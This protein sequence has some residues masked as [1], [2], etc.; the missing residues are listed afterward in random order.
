MTL[1]TPD[2]T[3]VAPVAPVDHD[4]L[5]AIET[6]GEAIR[7]LPK[8]PAGYNVRANV[9]SDKG[10]YDRALADINYAF[11]FDATLYARYLRKMAEAQGVTRTE[12]KIERVTQREGLEALACDCYWMG[13]EK[14][15][16]DLFEQARFHTSLCFD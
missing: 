6:A 11:H 10:D 13:Q 12:G 2:P 15:K 1:T 4:R 16:P 14:V 8:D 9:L 7:L 5:G 3:P